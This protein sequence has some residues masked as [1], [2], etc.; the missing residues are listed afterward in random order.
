MASDALAGTGVLVTRPRIQAA[1]LVDAIERHGGSAFCYPVLEIV[2]LDP[3]EVHAA[4]SAQPRPDIVIF[5]SR[6]AVEHGIAHTD[7]ALIAVIGPA[8]AQA[9][10]DAGRVVDIQPAA[11]S[12]SEHLLAEAALQD[13]A[14]KKI[15][16]I[17]GNQGRELLAEELRSRGASVDYLSVY[18]RRLPTV[19]PD[20]M[21][22]LERRWRQGDI[23][24]IT[25][26][27]VESLTNLS[28]ILPEWCAAQVASTPLVTPSGRVLKGA[29]DRYPA[30]RPVLASGPGAQDMVQAMIALHSTDSGTA[31]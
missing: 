13:V 25:V 27:S 2:P 26:M 6:N 31:P 29:L 21:A 18:E 16:I 12:D 5:V 24:V 8:T 9:V 15:R 22:E 14:G 3:H 28:K 11:G 17:R 19:D 1:E 30:S 10:R 20:M 4:A 7:G 23:N